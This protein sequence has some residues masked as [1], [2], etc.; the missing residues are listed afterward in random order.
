MCVEILAIIVRN[1]KD[2]K[3]IVVNNVEHKLS[4]YADDTEF[5]Q[6]GDR[7]SFENCIETINKFGNRSGLFMNNE[8]TS[9]IWLGSRKRS[10][11][12]YLQHLGMEWNP[13]KF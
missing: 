13:G 6:G 5:L 3:G 9:V 11:I 1:N 8:K 7:Q 2:I 4:Q 12:R 10:P